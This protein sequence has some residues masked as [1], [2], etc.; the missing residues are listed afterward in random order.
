MTS[1]LRCRVVQSREL[2]VGW[3][4][5]PRSGARPTRVQPSSS[6]VALA[7]LRDVPTHPTNQINRART[8]DTVRSP[9]VHL[10]RDFHTANMNAVNPFPTREALRVPAVPHLTMNQ[11]ERASALSHSVI[12][13]PK[14]ANGFRIAESRDWI[15]YSEPQGRQRFMVKWWLADCLVSLN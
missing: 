6:P 1:A 11:N 14:A 10:L 15:N 8:V 12:R 4:G 13:N 2:K 7:P 3:V 9:R 5:T